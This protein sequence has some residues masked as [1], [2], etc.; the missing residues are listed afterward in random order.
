MVL[1]ARQMLLPVIN[2]LHYLSK[3]LTSR[4]EHDV[5]RHLEA[6]VAL[7]GQCTH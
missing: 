1:N 6:G 5:N 3:M 4:N 7:L 2:I